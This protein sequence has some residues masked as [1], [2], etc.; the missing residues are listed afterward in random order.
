LIDSGG[1]AVRAVTL[2]LLAVVLTAV[3]RN[4]LVTPFE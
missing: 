4:R 1:G 2:A 3:F